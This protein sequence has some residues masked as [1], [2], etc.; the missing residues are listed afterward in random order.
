MDSIAREAVLDDLVRDGVNSAFAGIHTAAAGNKAV[1]SG[2]ICALFR[3]GF[4]NG[5]AAVLELI[6]DLGEFS[7]LLGAVDGL[8]YE[9]RPVVFKKRYF[10]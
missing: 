6:G 1:R 10:G 8:R 3:N 4:K 5:V 2:E 9:H 7:Q